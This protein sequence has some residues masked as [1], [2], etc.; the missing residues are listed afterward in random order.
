VVD[1]NSLDLA[2]EV[3]NA[4]K[5]RLEAEVAGWLPHLGDRLFVETLTA[6]RVDC[7]GYSAP[8]EPRHSVGRF[9]LYRD[10]FLEAGDRLVRSCEG[11]P[12]D[13]T[14]IYPIMFQ[15]R[16]HLELSLKGVI[17]SVSPSVSGLTKEGIEKE[18]TRVTREHSLAK[19]WELLKSIYPQCN[20]WAGSDAEAFN[21]LI[22][23][24]DNH[25]PDGQAPRYSMD[26]H[27]NQTLLGLQAVDLPTFKAGVHKMSHYLG[28]I[29][30]GIYQHE[31]WQTEVESY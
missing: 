23:E 29:L 27:G 31:T 28:A 17:C 12:I 20:D 21:S 30:E 24:F 18:R 11:Y 9:D 22:V 6:A 7:L 10:A 4:A 2:I 3:S 25:D 26:R 1:V 8:G 16:H 14:M 13:D 19:L 5:E 15:Y